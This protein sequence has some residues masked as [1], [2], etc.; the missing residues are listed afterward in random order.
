MRTSVCVRTVTG[1]LSVRLVADNISDYPRTNIATIDNRYILNNYTDCCD[2][3]RDRCDWQVSMVNGHS[4]VIE[5]MLPITGMV[6]DSS[7]VCITEPLSH[8]FF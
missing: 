4:I 1:Y 6:S 8:F 3:Y 7:G 2:N 5:Y